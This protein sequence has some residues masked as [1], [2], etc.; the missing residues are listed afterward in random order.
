[1]P[2]ED[3]LHLRCLMLRKTWVRVNFEL[4]GKDRKFG[5]H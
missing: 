1:M 3:S 5:A 2:G 4:H